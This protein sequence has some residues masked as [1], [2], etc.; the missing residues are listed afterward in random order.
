MDDV[1]S[2]HGEQN[3]IARNDAFRAMSSDQHNQDLPAQ[4][5]MFWPYT[6]V[7]EMRPSHGHMPGHSHAP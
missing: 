1:L 4:K 7:M 5:A 3:R 2:V 6:L